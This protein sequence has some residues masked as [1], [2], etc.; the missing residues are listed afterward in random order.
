MD[1]IEKLTEMFK[2]FPGIGERQARRFT[3][4][5]MYKNKAYAD[6]LASGIQELKKDI[7]QCK[8]C[9]RYFV[10]GRVPGPVCDMCSAPNVDGSLL[11]VVEKDSDL[12]SVHKSGAYHGKYF[13][14]GGL[15]PIV[16]KTTKSRVRIEELKQRVKNESQSL[17]E[18][19]LAFSLSPQGD[20]THVF[21]RGELSGI[22]D[23][24]GIKIST[25]GRGLSTGTELEYSDNDTLRNALKNRQ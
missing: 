4:F 3:Y 20:H 7:T 1:I 16:E 19:I 25:L 13:I 9:F 14:L 2:E 23:P 11:M 5:L 21:V 15:V 24:A 12:E 18:I 10:Q 6:Q 8:E 22:A 17:K